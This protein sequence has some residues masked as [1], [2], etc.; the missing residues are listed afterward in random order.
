[1]VDVAPSHLICSSV[2]IFSAYQSSVSTLIVSPPFFA[3]AKI[4]AEVSQLCHT[5]Y[6]YCAYNPDKKVAPPMVYYQSYRVKIYMS[7]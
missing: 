1:M 7:I 3:T 5:G 4:C 2:C 6:N